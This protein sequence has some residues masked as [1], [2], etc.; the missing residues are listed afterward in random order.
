[1]N[2]WQRKHYMAWAEPYHDTVCGRIGFLDSNIFHLW[3][4]DIEARG[5]RKRHQGLRPFNFDP[6]NDISQADTGVWRWNTAKYEMHDYVQ[7]YFSSR[8][9]DG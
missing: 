7:R 1:M 8:R 9:E 2:E 3:H 5:G 6:F 4:G